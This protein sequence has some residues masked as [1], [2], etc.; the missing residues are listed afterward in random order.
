MY[1]SVEGTPHSQSRSRCPIE[2]PNGRVSSYCSRLRFSECVQYSCS[3]N[4][5]SVG[6]MIYCNGSGY[7][8]NAASAC[9]CYGECDEGNKIIL[10]LLMKR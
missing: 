7:W 6:S 4:C 2:I 8:E 3:E 10:D 9:F 5:L 1:V